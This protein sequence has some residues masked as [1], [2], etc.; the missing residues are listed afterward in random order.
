MVVCW[1]CAGFNLTGQLVVCYLV[2]EQ[3]FTLQDALEAF[4]LSRPPG[5]YEERFVRAL[6]ARYPEH[7]RSAIDIKN[8]CKPFPCS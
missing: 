2:E 6:I 1:L 8:L 5:V 7:D 3:G 4:A